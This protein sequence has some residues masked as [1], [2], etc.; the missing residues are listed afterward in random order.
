[1]HR[2]VARE[3]LYV[4]VILSMVA[5][6]LPQYAPVAQAAPQSA[7]VGAQP[8]VT[9]PDPMEHVRAVLAE[10]PHNL[11]LDTV[12]GDWQ[13]PEQTPGTMVD[14][15]GGSRQ[16]APV[17]PG[18]SLPS[19]AAP[20]PKLPSLLE[21]VPAPLEPR[22]ID[23]VWANTESEHERQSSLVEARRDAPAPDRTFRLSEWSL[24]TTP[25]ITHTEA[26]VAPA[27]QSDVPQ[28]DEHRILLP[29]VS[30]NWVELG[31][32]G[33]TFRPPSSWSVGS[34]PS[35]ADTS[36]ADLA[37]TASMALVSPD[38]DY[39][40]QVL[41][42]WHATAPEAAFGSFYSRAPGSYTETFTWA[43]TR[44]LVQLLRVETPVTDSG[45][46]LASAVFRSGKASYSLQLYGAELD[47]V[48]WQLFYD[49]VTS[50]T[51][52]PENLPESTWAQASVQ[53]DGPQPEVRATQQV[54]YT[55]SAAVQ[56]ANHWTRLIP[57][58]NGDGHYLWEDGG[59]Q[60]MLSPAYR[61]GVDGAHFINMVL[62]AGGLPAPLL[63]APEA[64]Q[65]ASLRTWLLSNG[66][67]EISDPLVLLPGDV[68]FVGTGDCWGWGGVV[69]SSDS[70]GPLLNVHSWYDFATG[71]TSDRADVRY[72]QMENNH[73]GPT[74]SY[75]FVHID[76]PAGPPADTEPPVIH[77]VDRWLDG[78]GGSMF[79]AH[80]TDNVAVASVVL[81]FNGTNVQMQPVSVDLYEAVVSVPL[82]QISSW[83]VVAVDTSGN[84]A[85][86]P[87]GTP[88]DI[89]GYMSN[90]L[91]WYTFACG[92]GVDPCN[93]G[94]SGSVVDPVSTSNGNFTH[95]TTDLSVAGVGD[96]DIILE[97]GYN[98]LPNEPQGLIRYT[99]D[100]QNVVAEPQDVHPEPFGPGWTFPYAMS[101][102]IVDNV[103]LHG[104]QVRYPDGHTFNFEDGGDGTFTPVEA[105]VYDTLTWEGD[106]YVLVTKDLIS[107]HFNADGRLTHITDRN[108]NVLTLS[109]DGEHVVRVG[110]SA[111]RWVQFEYNGEG[112]ITDA[113]A[114]EE[115]HLVY[116]YQDGRLHSFMNGQ[117][118]T[119][120]YNYDTQGRLNDIVTPKG[121]SSLRLTYGG[122]LGRVTEQIIGAAER[123]TFVYDDDARTTT[124]TDAYDH[125]TTH[126]YD[127]E[128]RLVEV[129][130]H[131]DQSE[132]YDY[133]DLD[134]R[135]YFQDRN[136]NEWFYTY[137]HRGNR[138]TQDGPLG[139]YNEFEY[140]DLDLVTRFVEKVDVDTTRATTYG[141]DDRGNLTE[142]CNPLSGMNGVCSTIVYNPR[143]LPTDLWDFANSHTVNTYDAE[144][145]LRAITNAEDETTE[146]DHDGLGR[147]THMWTPLD[148]HYTYAYD[149]NDNLVAVDGPLGYHLGY[150]YDD[151]DNLEVEIDPNGGETSYDY[152]TSENLLSVVN[153]LLVTTAVY[154]YGDM[155]EML[156]FTDGEEHTWSYDYDALLRMTGIHGPLDTH[157]NFGY[158]AVGNVTDVTGP[159][160]HDTHTGYDA[161]YRP[162]SVTL[163][164]IDGGPIDPET[165]VKTSYEYD[166]VGNILSETDP[167]ENSTVYR[168]DL[169]DR[170]LY[171]RTAE[172]QEWEY[173]YYPM[174][175]VQQV[176][177]PRDYPIGF[178]YDR[179]YRLY[180][181]IDA[182][183][184]VITFEYD[185]DGNL[186]DEIDPLGLVTHY[187]Y[188]ELDRLFAEVR[189]YRPDQPADA[190]TNVTT[191]YQYDPAG[192][193]RTITEPRDYLSEFQYDAAHR[194]TDSYDFEGGHTHYEYDRVDNLLSVTDDNLHAKTYTYDDL[195]RRKTVANAEGHTVEFTYDK[196]GNVTDILDA[197]GSQIHYDVDALGRTMHME[198]ALGGHW[199][200]EYDRVSNV[201]V[202]TDANNHPTVYTYDDVYRLR[203]A[204]D[205][206]G[207]LSEFLYDANDNLIEFVDGNTHSTTYTYDELDRLETTINAEDETTEY[208]YDPLGSQTHLIEADGTVTLYRYDP[209]YRLNAVTENYVEG[210][211][212]DSDTNVLTRYTYDASG[213]LDWIV[214]ANEAVTDFGHDGMG[215]QVQEVDPLGNT[216]TYTYDGVGNRLTRLDANGDQTEYAYYPDDQLRRIDY[217]KDGTSIQYTY[218]ENN[219]RR[220]MVD[221]LGTTEWLYDALNR[222]TDVVD[223]FARALHFEYDRVGNRTEMVYPDGNVVAYGYYRND[224][225]KTMTDPTGRL[226]TYERD[227]VGNVTRTLNPNSTVTT[228]TYDKA[229]RVLTLRNEQVVGAMK[230]NSAF[231]YTYNNIGHVTQVVNEYGW[232]NPPVVTETYTYDGLH[233]LAGMEDS[234]GVVMAY[235]YD[236]VGNRLL[237]QTNDDL[238]TSTPLDGFAATY[239]YNAANQLITATVDSETPNGDVTIAFTYDGN[240]SRTG[241][242]ADLGNGPEYGTDYAYDPENRLVR[243]LDYKLV[244]GGNRIDGAITTLAYDGGGRRL[245]KSYDPKADPPAVDD[246]VHGVDKRV[247]YVFDG[248]DPVAEY[249]MLNGQRDNYYRGA[250][251]HI[252]T[253]HHFKSGSQGQMYW[254]HYNF[255]G[256][257]VGLTKHQGQSTHN[258][259]YDPYGGVVPANG[260]FTDPHNH[261]TLTGKEYDE[262][263]RFLYFGLRH[264][265]PTVS[266][267]ITKDTYRGVTVRPPSTHAYLFV[268]ANP[269]TYRDAYGRDV[270]TDEG[271]VELL[272][273]SLKEDG[274][275]KEW[276][277]G[278]FCGQYS[279][280]WVSADAGAELD[281]LGELGLSGD[282]G[283]VSV[284][285]GTILGNEYLGLVFEAE[286]Y[287]PKAETIAGL[288]DGEIGLNA[289]AKAAGVE[290][291]CMINVANLF[292]VGLGVGIGAEAEIGAKYSKKKG[293]VVNI[294][295]FEG[296]LVGSAPRSDSYY[297]GTQ[298]SLGERWADFKSGVSNWW[299]S[300]W[301]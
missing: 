159:E 12:L 181:T 102:L 210:A 264:Y 131:L 39:A 298:K 49:L 220:T 296:Q 114:P 65:I 197:R 43:R 83:Q 14:L 89:R 91:G 41:V 245:V 24:F 64:M 120:Y 139:F 6:F 237:W 48:T 205:A 265:D 249:D 270:D 94:Y 252:T 80:V 180:Q 121:H 2:S 32:P 283:T 126:I 203:T 23:D 117:L 176:L 44:E 204:T 87:P 25:R 92:Q 224:W 153:Q 34:S 7:N 233:R 190:Q 256:D 106:G 162:T 140:N 150:R 243:A 276:A 161:L 165:N 259:R 105:R 170:L 29:I 287:G 218:D 184:N 297:S 132:F 167:E 30:R 292:S 74:D 280:G 186:S 179:V 72:T 258:Y 52:R 191:E 267:W 95:Y 10:D 193:L 263:T 275:C 4:V 40:I 18:L 222:A 221:S 214:N 69:V 207:N 56:Y 289:G 260:N 198:D 192:N 279:A 225:L 103:L 54:S 11:A 194:L 240:G 79:R 21:A 182:Q 78:N 285:G 227:G 271:E 31:L 273:E 202:E 123:Y 157:T 17:S 286:G 118:K 46:M 290:G 215:R 272:D 3:L 15:P 164:Y 295:P 136:G 147:V 128:Q 84:P 47:D 185:D 168:Y 42:D 211:P 288:D 51:A 55:R 241:K 112:L 163:N 107:Y 255:K 146:Y 122:E 63:W 232:R 206:E 213:N 138:L 127:D 71:I 277:L 261:Y 175:Q 268:W 177:N 20:T 155:N 246:S 254:Y 217:G 158:D 282:V 75:S 27:W 77:S 50:A 9:A 251:G 33:L 144:G 253:M 257:V 119:T 189:N 97:R 291:R 188:D 38:G 293:V 133:N 100:G 169:L 104:V 248:L 151:N 99:W 62:S 278:S 13:G 1:M 125:H 81:V 143:G 266:S 59:S 229:N 196:V 93:P 239:D 130:N 19:V 171:K 284:T 212:A 26:E 111:G 195:D 82:N 199:Y 166:L 236:R 173:A 66:G 129:R 145:D 141:Y 73:C 110:N 109:Y 96:T 174:G 67:Q 22:A 135:T 60:C 244:G 247:E 238:T 219:N 28:S 178:V 148:Y 36:P 228:L 134:N 208:R 200:Y 160:E 299:N 61:S 187:D 90:N 242:L 137:D 68:V 209:L 262:H 142:I 86:F 58:C 45:S 223:P 101:L 216:W 35:L 269:V 8:T 234:D 37:D 274:G 250:L 108:G 116:G 57:L 183:G 156:S 226:T 235:A 149:P 301:D 5:G 113:Y 230:T 231:A 76:A 152:D 98:S 115:I 154:T 172:N 124:V 16:P 294:G 70:V 300:L 281:E 85:V 88:M 201:L 53:V